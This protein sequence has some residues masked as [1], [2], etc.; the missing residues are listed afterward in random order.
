MV[1]EESPNDLRHLFNHSSH[2]VQKYKK[3]SKKWLMTLAH[4]YTTVRRL[5]KAVCKC[6]ATL[7]LLPRWCYVDTLIQVPKNN[8]YMII[9]QNWQHLPWTNKR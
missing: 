4:P 6:A 9:F 7:P 8:Y 2:L 1:I 5:W 3:M